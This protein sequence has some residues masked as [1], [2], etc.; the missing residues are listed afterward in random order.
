MHAPLNAPTH[1]EPMMELR[2]GRRRR[3][4][5]RRQRGG[6][7]PVGGTRILSAQAHAPRARAGV[8]NAALAHTPLRQCSRG[9]G[10]GRLRRDGRGGAGRAGART[11]PLRPRARDARQ[12]WK[13]AAAA[14]CVGAAAATGYRAR[15]AARG[16]TEGP[17]AS[18]GHPTAI[19]APPP[20]P[21]PPGRGTPGHVTVRTSPAA[22]L[23]R[24]SKH[25]SSCNVRAGPPQ[26]ASSG[27]HDCAPVV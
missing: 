20:P 5:M 8:L 19:P 14:S 13:P 6:G 9:A 4:A 24:Q 11:R 27:Q 16:A 23:R 26:D 18:P 12:A 2:R 17:G 25:Y 22:T 7:R 3:A 15:G 21:H 1:N 10:G